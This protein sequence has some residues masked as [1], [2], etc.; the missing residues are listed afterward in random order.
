[1]LL[2]QPDDR[3]DDDD[4]P[5]GTILTG[6]AI[7]R[8]YLYVCQS[9]E[10]MRIERENAAKYGVQDIRDFVFVLDGTKVELTYAE[11]KARLLTPNV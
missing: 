7:K 6:S 11:L 4:E 1:M 8:A 10:R 2:T 5:V 3:P 9:E